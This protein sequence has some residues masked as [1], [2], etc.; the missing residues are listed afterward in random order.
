MKAILAVLMI[1]SATPALAHVEPGRYV[2]HTADGVACTMDVTAV[3]FE[4]NVPHPLNERVEVSLVNGV[5]FTLSHLP[6]IDRAENTVRPQGG[7]LTGVR[8]VPGAADAVI[9]EMIHSE[10]YTGPE[11]LTILHDDYKDA[12]KSSKFECLQVRKQGE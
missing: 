4:G 12:T 3:R 7:V 10:P 5:A 8:G 6:Q 11:T 9:L 1:L 2:G